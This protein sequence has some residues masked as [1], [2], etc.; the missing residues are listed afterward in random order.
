MVALSPKFSFYATL[1]RREYVMQRLD[2]KIAIIT[3]ATS[4]MGRCTAERFVE[5]GARIIVCG[6]R[7]QLGRSLENAFATDRCHF[8]KA[9]VTQEA[10]VK[11]LIDACVSRWGR[12]DCLF[13]NAG[14]SIA[15]NGIETISVADFDWVINSVLRSAMLGMKHVAPIM[16]AQKTGSII[17]NGSIA[18]RQA[19]YSSSLAYGAAKAGVIHLTRCVAMQ[20]GEHNVR[21]NSISPGAI[22]TGIFAKAFG[23]EAN[24]ADAVAGL[25]QAAFA[26]AQPIPRAGSADDI[27]EAAVFLASDGSS[28]VNGQDLVVDG[29]LAGGRL[30]AVQRQSL[31]AMREALGNGKG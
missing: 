7:A 22:P 25:V 19:G 21:V 4:G 8:I 13:N 10:D 12:V 31:Q 20:L 14:A 23:V 30:W 29:G 1:R 16:M 11:G 27:A 2:G 26:K 28:F 6:R 9:D 15:D 18:G 17:N 3:G 5:E 24:K